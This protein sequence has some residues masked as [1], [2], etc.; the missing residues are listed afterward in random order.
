MSSSS[1]SRVSA[2]TTPLTIA[3]VCFPSFGGSG[4]IASEL[5]FALALRGHRVHVVSESVPVR[6]RARANGDAA[7]RVRFHDVGELLPGGPPGTNDRI[8]ALAARLI[9]VVTTENVDVIHA[10]YALPHAVAAH[11]AREALT[12]VARPRLVTTLHGTDVTFAG[13]DVGLRPLTRLAALAS[14]VVTTPSSFLRD[15]AIRDLALPASRPV[16]VVQNFVDTERFVPSVDRSALRAIF[17]GIDDETPV[18]THVSNFRA[19]KRTG[20]VVDVFA[21]M[22]ADTTARLLM[23]GD[24]PEREEAERRIRLLGLADRVVFL[25]GV[26]SFERVLAASTVFLLPSASESFGLAA[27]EAMSAGVA[28][29][30]TDQGG[31]REVVRHGETG[32]LA[33]VGDIDALTHAVRRIVDDEDLRRALA[34]RARACVLAHFECA[35]AIDRYE[36]LYRA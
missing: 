14:D 5:A 9:E 23:I 2:T 16:E 25:G 12:G 29:V 10:H 6:L 7:L 20:D 21:R 24:G 26:D 33:P 27:L 32:F 19:V 35:P 11:L 31:L 18:I 22:A 28:V 17:A 36:A 15:V 30:A 34:S 8:L 3:I 1:S 4:V 13:V